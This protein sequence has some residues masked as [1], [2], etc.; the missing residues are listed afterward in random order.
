MAEKL[1]VRRKYKTNHAGQITRWWFLI[2]GDQQVLLNLEKLW[3]YV[4][5]QTSSKLEPC[6]KFLEHENAGAALSG[7]DASMLFLLQKLLHHRL[8]HV[9]FLCH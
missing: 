4:A 2:H 7:E 8:L 5:A 1:Q 6:L 3:E 9:R